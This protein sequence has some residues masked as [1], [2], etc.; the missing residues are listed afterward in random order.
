MQIRDNYY[1]LG[2]G[3]IGM[4]AL[5]RYFKS[6]GAQVAGYDRYRSALCE[7]LEAEG[8]SLHYEDDPA[9]LPE[10]WQAQN[11][12]VVYTPAVPA[13]HREMNFM[14]EAGFE[15]RKRASVL[16][17]IAR[18]HRCL[19][20][21]G[22]HGKTTTS[23]LLA[24]LF[25]HSEVPITA[26]LGGLSTNYQ[27]NFW[28]AADSEIL[29]AEADEYDRSF[30]QLQAHGAVITS[31]EADH[32]DIYG[33]AQELEES[34]A[35]FASSV[36]NFLLVHE[37]LPLPAQAT[38]GWSAEADFAA[39]EVR[40]VEQH[41]RFSLR[42]PEGKI[43]DLRLNLPGR[44][45]LENAVAA[46]A[47]A[48]H[49]GL[50][51]EQISAGLASFKGVKRRFEFHIKS[52]SLS[53]IDDY[54]HH[55]G[56]INAVAQALKE[57]YPQVPATVIFQPHLYSRTRDFMDQFAE[58]LSHFAEVILLELYPAREKPIPGI[59]SAA[60]L[61]KIEAP[62]KSL[63][64]RQEIITRFSKE[65]PAL[66]ITLGAGD[67]DQLVNPLKMALLR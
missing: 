59:S 44:H 41:Y 61:E 13:D 37:N 55:P 57:F 65:K 4:S 18:E 26:F 30:L 31:M 45:N 32:L 10:G 39:D 66:V 49:Y 1:F 48:L 58:S 34:F 64:G 16:A 36:S 46:A 15:L 56:E 14:R 27:S 67:I 47:L 19:A 6:R 17:E 54:A 38:Y 23:A 43:A 7:K 60:L 53:Y 63:M 35:Q 40:V 3:G 8:M 28:A 50:E 11:S 9:L 25:R 24:H 20:V 22:T 42:H 5:A 52:K 51:P 21:A 2:I 62:R 12:T 29:V 33:A